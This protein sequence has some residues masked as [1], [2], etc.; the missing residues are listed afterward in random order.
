MCGFKATAVKT[1]ARVVAGSHWLRTYFEIYKWI[2]IGA[3]S[4]RR[5]PNGPKFGKELG[6][7]G[8]PIGLAGRILH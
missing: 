3:L 8:K 4:A 5:E 2:Q 7:G 1:I 6:N